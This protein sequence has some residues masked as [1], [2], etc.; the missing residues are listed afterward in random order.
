MNQLKCNWV[1]SF[2]IDLSGVVLIK[3][4]WDATTFIGQLEIAL[5]AHLVSM[6]KVVLYLQLQAEFEMKI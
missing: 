3:S 5:L 6:T 4:R 2:Y 1:R